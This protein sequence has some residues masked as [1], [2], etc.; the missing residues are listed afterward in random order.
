[1]EHALIHG[2]NGRPY[3]SPNNPERS[4][5]RGRADEMRPPGRFFCPSPSQAVEGPRRRSAPMPM[6]C[7]PTWM[8]GYPSE[9]GRPYW[10]AVA[11]RTSLESRRVV[12]FVLTT[13]Y[14]GLICCYVLAVSALV[15]IGGGNRDAFGR[16]RVC[17]TPGTS[18]KPYRSPSDAHRGNGSANAADILDGRAGLRGDDTV[19]DCVFPGRVDRACPT[20][21]RQPRIRP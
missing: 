12:K 4:R 20:H 21:G 15:L 3:C 7:S 13:K 10:G 6:G 8:N 5:T 9:R 1:M 18:T 11:A 16:I 2:W 19:A 14:G 17:L